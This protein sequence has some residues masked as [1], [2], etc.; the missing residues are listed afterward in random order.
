MTITTA[1]GSNAHT[2]KL[3]DSGG[4][5]FLNWVAVLIPFIILVDMIPLSSTFFS[6]PIKLHLKTSL[7]GILSSTALQSNLGIMPLCE[8]S[9]RWCPGSL[10]VP[11]AHHKAPDCILTWLT[12][13]PT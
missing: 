12:V 7:E 10:E 4:T 11:R 2:L 13:V 3:A 9:A 8:W 5:A 1:D 6:T